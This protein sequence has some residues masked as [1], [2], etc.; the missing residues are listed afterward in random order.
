MKT[1]EWLQD[2]MNKGLLCG[3][4]TDKVNEAKSKKQL[5]QIVLDANGINF[6]MEMQAKGYPLPYEVICTEFSSYL[7]G[8]YIAEYKNEKGNGYSSCMY[9]CFDGDTINVDTTICTVLGYTGTINVVKNN[10]A[11]IVLDKNCDVKISL[12]DGAKAKVEYWKGAKVEVL[13]NYERV[14]L[15]E[16]GE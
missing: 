3:N 7:N 4:Y 5:M 16:N 1:N 12:E 6:L 13:G 9:C 11:Y 10:Y 15:I 2:I 14:N 8:R